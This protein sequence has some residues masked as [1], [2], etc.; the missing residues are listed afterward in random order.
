MARARITGSPPPMRTVNRKPWRSSEFPWGSKATQA[1]PASG[2]E[3]AAS[4]SSSA[5]TARYSSAAT[6]WRITECHTTVSVPGSSL[7][8]AGPRLQ[9]ELRGKVHDR[10]VLPTPTTIKTGV[11]N[12]YPPY[13][14][15]FT[16]GSC[17]RM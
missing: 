5:L 16:V 13:K 1:N 9:I 17:S 7:F 15:G 2:R 8:V 12:T 10:T 14:C 3:F 4:R 6:Y 11:G